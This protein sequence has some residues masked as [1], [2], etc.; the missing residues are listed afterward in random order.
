MGLLIKTMDDTCHI[1]DV[2]ALTWDSLGR[3]G[4]FWDSFE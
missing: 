1:P 2:K 4:M 3:F